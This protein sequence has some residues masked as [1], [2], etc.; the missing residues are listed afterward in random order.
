MSRANKCQVASNRMRNINRGSY[1][2]VYRDEQRAI[3]R[4]SM[5]MVNYF[6]SQGGRKW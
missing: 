5:S 3:A 4:R 2:E 1:T 6:H